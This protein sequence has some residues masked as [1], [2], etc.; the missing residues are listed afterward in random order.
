MRKDKPGRVAVQQAM[1]K[2]GLTYHTIAARMHTHP[3]TAW[4]HIA[5]RPGSN[6]TAWENR[7]EKQRARAYAIALHLLR[8]TPR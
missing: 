5:A 7:S 2:I 1:R 3:R 8:N 4:Q 6:V